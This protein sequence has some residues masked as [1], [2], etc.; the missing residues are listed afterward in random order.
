LVTSHLT[1]AIVG[2]A[3][4]SE[5]MFSRQ[6]VILWTIIAVSM[7]VLAL[8]MS[9]SPLVEI[10]RFGPLSADLLMVSLVLGLIAGG[11]WGIARRLVADGSPKV[12]GPVQV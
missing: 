10:L 1:L 12:S 3:S 9:V 8:T 6:R 5:L 2:A 4:S 11:W 7:V